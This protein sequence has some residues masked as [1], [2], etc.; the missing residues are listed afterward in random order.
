M[1]TL[2]NLSV[3]KCFLLYFW[4]PMLVRPVVKSFFFLGKRREK[5]LAS[6]AR[7]IE[8]SAPKG[9]VKL[10]SSCN[11]PSRIIC[12]GKEQ[13]HIHGIYVHPKTIKRKARKAPKTNATRK[14][15]TKST[16]EAIN[17]TQQA[18]THHISTDITYSDGLCS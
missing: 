8:I 17:V 15:G 13:E 4:H 16:T 1:G 11:V 9:T 14:K 12:N 5:R 10:L 3:E 7:L 2:Q 18:W 6:F